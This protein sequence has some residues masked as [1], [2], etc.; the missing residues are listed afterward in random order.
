LVAEIL[1]VGAKRL[2]DPQAVHREQQRKGEVT[3]ATGPC[4]GDERPQFVPIKPESLG[5]VSESRSSNKSGR[6][7]R[8]RAL[9]GG[10]RIEA[11]ERREPRVRRDIESRRVWN[12]HQG[13]LLVAGGRTAA[14]V[15]APLVVYEC[16]PGP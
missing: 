12:R 13:Y 5:V 1:D 10:V 16:P 4:R 2:G 14:T 6:R 15:A 9:G 3:R 11:R 7:S 8:D